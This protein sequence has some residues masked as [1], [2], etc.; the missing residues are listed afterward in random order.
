MRKTKKK[1]AKKAAKIEQVQE[2]V[3]SP[4]TEAQQAED[5]PVALAQEDAPSVVVPEVKHRGRKA[6]SEK[7]ETDQPKH[8]RKTKIGKVAEELSMRTRKEKTG[9][10][11][12][13]EETICLQYGGQELDVA[14][15]REQ[16]I[17]TYVEAG[18]RRGRISKLNL[19]I[20]PEDHKVY[21]VIN[22]KVSGSI[23]F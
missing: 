16:V 14:A 4:A 5:T 17:A 6:K 23:D 8:N 21:Y 19:Y 18:H 22:D 15:L 20:K 9:L 2:P 13:V 10:P 3:I 12:N 7:P 11:A 1:L